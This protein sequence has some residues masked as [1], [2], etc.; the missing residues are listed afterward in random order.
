[1]P[2]GPIPAGQF[3]PP[4][5]TGPTSFLDVL[6]RLSPNYTNIVESRKRTALAEQQ[7]R[8]A[9]ITTLI[10]AAEKIAENPEAFAPFKGLL[11]QAAKAAGGGIDSDLLEPEMVDAWRRAVRSVPKSQKAAALKSMQEQAEAAAEKAVGQR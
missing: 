3:R 8:M 6:A 5:E 11:E 2:P 10:G 7:Q 1:M 4:K 9:S